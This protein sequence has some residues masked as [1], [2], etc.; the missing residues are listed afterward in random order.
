ML[1]YFLG[2]RAIT[3]ISVSVGL[4]DLGLLFRFVPLI[5]FGLL[6]VLAFGLDRLFR[7]AL[8]LCRDNRGGG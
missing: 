5:F 3:S 4:S 1:W 7:F 8:L 2:S 6:L